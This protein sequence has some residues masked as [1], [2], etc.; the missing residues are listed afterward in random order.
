V[1]SSDTAS[2]AFRNLRL[3]LPSSPEKRNKTGA[4]FDFGTSNS[5]AALFDGRQVQIVKLEHST[6]VMPSACYIDTQF[7][8]ETGE[9]AIRR[10]IEENR[11]RRVELSA[12][13]LGEARLS[14][15]EIDTQSSLPTTAGTATI[16][17]RLV[18][19][20]GMPGRLFF[21]I[22][23]LLGTRT[24][25]GVTVFG[26]PFRLVAL[27]TP[28]LKQM[29]TKVER[30]LAE[31]G[32]A[33]DKLDEGCLGH[34]VVFEGESSGGNEIA[35]DRL[36]EAYR[37]A[38]IVEQRLCPEPIAAAISY[39]HKNPVNKPFR[40]LTVD[41]GGGTLD[42]C[43]IRKAES[44]IEVEA[45]HG[46]ALGGNKIDQAIFR[47]LLFP[48]L[49]QGERWSRTVEGRDIETEFP[50]WMYEERLLNWQVSYTLNQN[51]FTTPVLDQI[52][53]EGDHRVKF[54]RLYD[55]IT[56]NSVFEVFQVIKRAKETLSSER[57]VVI[58]LPEIDINI[59]LDREKFESI[60]AGFIG[61]FAAAVDTTLQI[62]RL[63]SDAI[64]VV[65]RTGG[66][67]LIP[68]FAER[69][70]SRFPGKV[71]EHDTFTG[72]AA[73]LAIADYFGIGERAPD[74]C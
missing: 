29:C 37:H 74:G 65:I 32:A 12:E 11:G 49:G 46:I 16:Y 24:T 61:E 21:G 72:V 9:Q 43:V 5:A 64:D 22:K 7:Q 62:A 60:I 42:L 71:V 8:V 67:A 27:V 58:D 3:T 70:D 57:E 23:R 55:L 53:T 10:Y 13:V 52:S 36:C 31:S 63:E 20:A 39:L 50:F 18:N 33:T 35:R 73:G 41:F 14:T 59:R 26:K 66:S 25:I 34:P 30:V 68:A 28:I 19:D 15:G 17:G 6:A 38:G 54:L 2:T 1:S 44:A 56:N 47:E 45:V 4:G 69:L 48:L 51:R 40:A